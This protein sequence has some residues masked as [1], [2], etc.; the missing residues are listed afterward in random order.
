MRAGILIV[1]MTV[2]MV[3]GAGTAAAEDKEPTA[4]V[5]I[6]GVGEWG[7][8]GPAS[9][10][11]SVSVEFTPIK[12]WLEIEIGAATLFRRGVTELETDLIFKTPIALSDTMEVMVGAGPARN[13]ARRLRSSSW[14]GPARSESSAGSSSRP[15]RSTRTARN[16]SPSASAC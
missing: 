16:R 7:L 15:T 14:S 4:V 2:G 5:A 9:F 8:P 11:P 12:D 10:G 3:A 6:G 13:G 1:A